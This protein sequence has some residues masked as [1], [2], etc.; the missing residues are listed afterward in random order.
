MNPTSPRR[1]VITGLG[2]ISPLGNSPESLWDALLAGRTGVGPLPG[3]TD[4]GAEEGRVQV[5]REATLSPADITNGRQHLAVAG[6]ITDERRVAVRHV[7][8]GPIDVT[9]AEH[10]AFVGSDAE[11]EVP[12]DDQAELLVVRVTVV[13]GRADRHDRVRRNTRLLECDPADEPQVEP[14]LLGVVLG[15]PPDLAASLALGLDGVGPHLVTGPLYHAAPLLFAVYD[16]IGGA[17]TVVMPR[18]AKA[19]TVATHGTG[20]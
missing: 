2:L 12:G 14:G 15:R 8:R 11:V 6:R 19:C 9:R 5:G 17:P 10:L 7:R 20:L 13:R 1:V 16:L 3:G 18:C 4:V